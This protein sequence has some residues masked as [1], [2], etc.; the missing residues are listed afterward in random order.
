[1]LKHK[2]IYDIPSHSKKVF[3]NMKRQRK[4]FS[5]AI[6]PLFDTMMVQAA[7]EVGEGSELPTDPHH[8][9]IVTQPST[10]SQPQKKDRYKRKQ[11]KEI[12]VPSPS[13]EIPIKENVPTTFNDPLPSGKNRIQLPELMILCTNLQR[14]VLDLEMA[15]T[16]QAK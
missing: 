3:A 10:S 5:R 4:D 13:S 8:I 6:T 14:Q 16:A 1:M 15:K 9:P 2:E 7:E 11:R 12:E